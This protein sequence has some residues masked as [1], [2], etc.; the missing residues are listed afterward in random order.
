MRSHQVHESSV[1]LIIGIREKPLNRTQTRGLFSFWRPSPTTTGTRWRYEHSRRAGLLAESEASSTG[2]RSAHSITIPGLSHPIRVLHLT[3]IHIRKTCPW[4]NEL[5]A[6]ISKEQPDLVVITGD[7]VTK[8]WTEQAVRQFFDALPPARLGHFAVMGNW[9]HWSAHL[10]GG[11]QSVRTR[12][13]CNRWVEREGIAIAGTDDW[14][15][16]LI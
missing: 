8:G 1:S 15:D 5:C 11:R 14:L 10:T 3:D 16:N 6:E 7:V 4:L 2:S 9:E 13:N 12:M